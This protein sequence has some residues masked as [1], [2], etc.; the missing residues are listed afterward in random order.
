LDI[1]ENNMINAVGEYISCLNDAEIEA[2][3]H[4]LRTL[5][6]TLLKLQ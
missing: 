3:S 6:D 5:R 1:H 4:S 2:L